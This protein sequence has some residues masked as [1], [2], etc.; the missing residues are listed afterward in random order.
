MYPP[1]GMTFDAAEAASG[2]NK[3]VL[4]LMKNLY[5]LKQAGRL[6]NQMLDEK[7]RALKY[8]QSSVDMCLYYRTDKTTVILVGIYV[9]DLLVTS[10]NLKLVDEFFEQMKAFDV[11]DLGKAEKFLGIKIESETAIGYSMSQR[12]MIDNLVVQFGLKDAKPVGTPIAEVVHAAEDMNLLSAQDVSLFRTLAGALLWIARCTRPDIGFAVHQMTRRTHAPRICDFKV[13]KR[14]LRYLCGTSEYKLEVKRSGVGEKILLEVYTDADWASENTDRKSVNA[15]LTYLNGMLISWHCNKQSLVSLSTMESEFVS[16]SRGIQEVM[17]CYHMI[18][19]LGQ[20]V[21]L[22]IQLRMD[23]QAAIA[24]IMNEA[25]S[26]KTKHVDIRHKFI[27]DLYR[28]KIVLPSYV[29]TTNMKA[30]ILTKI[31]P[32]PTFVRLRTMIGVNAPTYHE[33]KIRGGVLDK[34]V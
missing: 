4:K 2:G 26:S 33:G 28:L 32:A 29:T 15:G 18:K 9:D 17:G 19:E 30:D 10:N 21:E 5:G 31:M 23:N 34:M 27:K 16:A 13:G 25:S 12:A 11:K 6:W 20:S 14:I 1:Q 8:K 3:P 7:L 22:P 24:T